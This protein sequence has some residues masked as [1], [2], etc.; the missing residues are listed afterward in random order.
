MN[1]ERTKIVK[2]LKST[3]FLAANK[4]HKKKIKKQ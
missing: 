3:S 1:E 4:T 2:I